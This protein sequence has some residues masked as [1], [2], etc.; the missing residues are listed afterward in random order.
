MMLL[1]TSSSNHFISFL[2]RLNVEVAFLKLLAHY[3]FLLV[4]LSLFI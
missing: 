3:F 2:H 1:L 4:V